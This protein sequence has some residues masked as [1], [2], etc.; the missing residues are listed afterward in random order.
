[1]KK[2]IAALLLLVLS[3]GIIVLIYST[4]KPP[5]EPEGLTYVEVVWV[6]D[7]DTIICKIDGKEE[8]VRL[9]GID[10]PESVHHNPAFNTDEGKASSEYLKN[11]LTGKTVGLE[12]DQEKVDRYGRTLAY[13][14][15]RG[16]LINKKILEEGHARL[17]IIEPN[18]K[19]AD[20]LENDYIAPSYGFPS[21]D[22]A[23]T[24]ET[25]GDEAES[26]GDGTG[27]N[28]EES[29]SEEND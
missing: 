17:M 21:D 10:A 15:Y 4:Q 29:D 22:A 6:S 7:G 24:G 19:Y 3:F 11:M 23:T 14:W 12:F 13:V 2:F 18:E 20:Y 5:T 8:T 25:T 26:A 1:M 28:A 9:I 16:E 27:D